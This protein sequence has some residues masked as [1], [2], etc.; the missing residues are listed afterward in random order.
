MAEEV[1][2]NVRATGASGASRELRGTS[3]ELD[4]FGRSTTGAGAAAGKSEGRLK[5]FNKSYSALGGF[6]AGPL[7]LAAGGV[8]L[9]KFGV[10]SI[11]AA[12][13][14]EQAMGAMDSVFGK[15]ARAIKAWA[16]DAADSVG[17]AKSEYGNLAVVLG[18][19]LKNQGIK[20][21]TGQTHELIALGGDLA[22]QFGGSTKE[23]VEAIGSLMRGE[24]D[25]I[26]RY[27][28]SINQTGINARLA[29][30][31]QDKLKGAA[32]RT[33][34]AH[35]RLFLLTKQ[36]ASAQGAFRRESNTLAGSQQRLSA[37]FTNLK[38]T[39]GAKLLPVVTRLVS[40][41][42]N[43]IAG[44]NRTS[45]VMR[46]IGSIIRSVVTPVIQSARRAWQDI[47]GA[48]QDSRKKGDGFGTAMRTIGTIVRRVAPIV[49]KIMGTQVRLL[50]KI[51][52]GVIT[53]INGFVNG[54]RAIVTWCQ[55]ARDAVAGLVNALGNIHVPHISLPR[56]PGIFRSAPGTGGITRG[57]GGSS[58]APVSFSP[59]LSVSPTIRVTIGRREIRQVVLEVVQGEL[60]EQTRRD[61]GGGDRE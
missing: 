5:R 13:D 24:T 3:R 41:L 35:A 57:V 7:A 39:I 40:W 59:M 26:E 27:G 17:L 16:G 19:M 12:S 55:N 34:Q 8:A 56:L 46:R 14:T 42:G 9:V 33:A 10:S 61:N 15:N 28:V 49:G 4:R 48:I 58:A 30:T 2:I 54:I 29:A 45:V 1:V 6:K 50:G 37:R 22:A 38:S 20:E 11:Q 52:A 51:I 60:R 43:T 47:T 36:T 44:T 31:G 53:G 32:L 21:F 23:A 25:P 18:S